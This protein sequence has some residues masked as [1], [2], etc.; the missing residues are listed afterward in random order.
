MAMQKTRDAQAMVLGLAGVASVTGADQLV[1]AATGEAATSANEAQGTTKEANANARLSHRLC[2]VATTKDAFE[3]GV[4]CR[5]IVNASLSTDW[6]RRFRC[7]AHLT[8]V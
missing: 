7:A 4:G 1:V 2:F 6:I 5:F 8:T 3:R